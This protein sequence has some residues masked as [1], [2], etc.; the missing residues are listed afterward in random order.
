M[1]QPALGIV[2]DGGVAALTIR[3]TPT[4]MVDKGKKVVCHFDEAC[5]KD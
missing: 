2:E 4:L 5:A 1:Q 3:R